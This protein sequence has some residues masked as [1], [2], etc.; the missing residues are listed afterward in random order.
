MNNLITLMIVRQMEMEGHGQQFE[1]PQRP[2]A[3]R[4]HAHPSDLQHVLDFMAEQE[5]NPPDEAQAEMIELSPPTARR[6]HFQ[7]G[8]VEWVVEA[9]RSVEPGAPQFVFRS[10]S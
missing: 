10:V 9:D 3:C 5:R 6:L 7:W 8:R 1:K 2:R 4:V